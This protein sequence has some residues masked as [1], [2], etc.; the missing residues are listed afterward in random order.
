MLRVVFVAAILAF[1][2]SAQ[3]Q[4][5]PPLPPQPAGVAWPGADW[6]AAQLP[7]DVDRAAYD[8]A[9]T[10]AFAGVHPQMG[11]T[12]AV[13]I[14]Q[15]GRLVFERYGDGYTRDTRLN[16]WSVGK[17]I[18][19]ALVGAAVL[20]GR[21]SIDAPM[22]NPAWRAG[23]R[24]ASI[25]WRQWMQ[26]VDGLDYNENAANVAEAGNA[27]ML[28]GEGRRDVVGW[29]ASRPLIHDPGTHWNYSSAGTMLT[30]DAL[31]RVVVPQPSDAN[32]RRARM[33]AWM[34]S[35]LFDRIGMH[36]VVEFDPQGAFYGSSLYWASARD[37]ARFGYLYLRD[38]V[39]N[40]ERILPEG[41]VE[42]ART[43]GPDAETDIYGAQWWLTPSSGRGRP[44]RSLIIDPDLTDAFSAQGH[45]GQIIVVVPSKD[46][47]LVRL[48]RFDG[49]AEAWDA[50]GDWAGRL[51]GAFGDR[52]QS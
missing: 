36:P 14:V 49:G 28:F 52:P 1:A 31:T 33:R 45:E 29:A 5:L 51:I 19:H 25:T 40:G 6:E 34:N 46:L 24:R 38:G 12:R 18:T 13:V 16:S 9:V 4:T 15:G 50:L 3:A 35:S 47:V 11:E 20:Q 43:P 8:L 41:W 27:R 10:E 17:S 37:Y 23:D 48:G 32:D 21:L 42:F 39:W 7:A 22:G 44:S 2:A 30:A 26:M